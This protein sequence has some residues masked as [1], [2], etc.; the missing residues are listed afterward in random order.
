M[1]FGFEFLESDDKFLKRLSRLYALVVM[2]L[3]WGSQVSLVSKI[4]PRYVAS[5]IIGISCPNNLSVGFVSSISF[6]CRGHLVKT[7]SCDFN[8]FRATNHFLHQLSIARTPS[9]I[10]F[11]VS[12][13]ELPDDHI[14]IS[15]AN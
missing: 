2:L 6:L 11:I 12:C 1:I 10:V 15:S 3:N 7:T 8:G 14:P 13:T 9:W 5:A 4:T